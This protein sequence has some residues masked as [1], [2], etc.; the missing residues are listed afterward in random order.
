MPC[1]HPHQ[2]KPASP[3]ASAQAKQQS[4]QQQI[5]PRLLTI[6]QAAVYLSAATWAVRELLW[7]RTIPYVAIGRRHLIDRGDLDRYIDDKLRESVER[8]ERDR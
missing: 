7:S 3:K 4:H 1:D 2:T 6:K 5:T 8:R